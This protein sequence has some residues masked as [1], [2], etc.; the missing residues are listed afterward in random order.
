MLG[1]AP[2]TVLHGLI[3]KIPLRDYDVIP[4]EDWDDKE[5]NLADLVETV[6]FIHEH[7]LDRIRVADMKAKLAY[8]AR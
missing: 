5:F 6:K 2:F 3:P 8:D 4:A 7:V 1:V